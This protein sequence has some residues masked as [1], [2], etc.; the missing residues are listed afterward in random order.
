MKT[1]FTLLLTLFTSYTAINAQQAK[2]PVLTENPIPE[3][4][5]V[6]TKTNGFRH[7]CIEKGVLTM[8]ELGRENGFIALQTETSEDFNS[9]NL[10]NYR[11]V[12]FMNT[13]EDVLNNEQQKAFKAYIN[14]GGSF[15]GVHA[16]SDTEYEWEW[17]GKM[18]GAY[19]DGHPNN[20][21]V[22]TA[23]L[24]VLD[25]EH[26]SCQHLPVRWERTDEWYNFKNLNPEVTVTLMLDESTYEGGTNGDNHPM[27]WYHEYDGGRAY[28]TG[29]GHTKA[30]FD[31]PAF[32][33]HLLGAIEWCMG[34]K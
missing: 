5:L 23:S 26:P 4:V 20:P 7:D 27:A 33:Q 12:V 31:E 3:L 21:N 2:A 17:Y 1:Y 32:R 30:T 6:F 19:F 9:E 16:A 15:L 13:T 24:D 11:L 18:V 14:Q 10:K 28:Y 25:K 8:R 22:R 34:R 29:G